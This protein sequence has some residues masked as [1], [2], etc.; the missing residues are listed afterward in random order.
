M[1]CLYPMAPIL[2]SK[3]HLGFSKCYKY[4]R[5]EDQIAYIFAEAL[6]KDQFESNRLKLGMLNM[7]YSILT[8]DQ[9]ILILSMI[10]R[11][12]IHLTCYTLCKLRSSSYQ[13]VGINPWKAQ[14]QR[15]VRTIQKS[16]FICTRGPC[17]SHCLHSLN[18]S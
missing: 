18:F 3:T 14:R 12:G 15:M 7:I 1:Q 10:W 16:F 9:L 2:G 8:K 4:C 13:I 11:E 17:P 6:S 5:T